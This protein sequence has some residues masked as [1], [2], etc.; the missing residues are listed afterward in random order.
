AFGLVSI[1]LGPYCIVLAIFPKFVL[2]K[3]F[4]PQYAREPYVLS[5][6]SA[7]A[8]MT[9][10]LLVITAAFSARRMTRDIFFGSV[11]GT[12]VAMALCWP[13]IRWMGMAGVIAAMAGST[14]TTA[15]FLI[16]RYRRTLPGSA[17]RGFEV[18]LPTQEQA[19]PS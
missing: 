11:A 18:V 12:V 8:M 5:F 10:W 4:D 14:I 7:Q 9:Y 1:L 17:Q 2:T 13:L 16:W 19:C 6:Y 3:V 15:I